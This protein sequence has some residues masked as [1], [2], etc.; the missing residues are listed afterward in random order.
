MRAIGLFLL[1]LLLIAA[2]FFSM[3][4]REAAELGV[5]PLS[6][7]LAMPLFLPILGG[8]AGGFLVG[9]AGGWMGAGA[10]RKQLRQALRE[11]RDLEL[12]NENLKADLK[13]AQSTNAAGGQSAAPGANLPDVAA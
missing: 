8:L 1:L 10:A 2:V 5:W 4:N 13:A 3:A 12:E 11:R 7:R 9:Y 6:G